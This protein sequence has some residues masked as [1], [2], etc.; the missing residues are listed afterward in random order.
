MKRD[1]LALAMVFAAILLFTHEAWLG[2]QSPYG[3]D[4]AEQFYPWKSF[5]RAQL[6]Q[7]EIPYWSPYTHAGAPFLANVQSAVFY[8]FDWVLFGFAMER[9]FGLSLVLHFLIA[10]AGAYC[11]ARVCG[12]T[13][14]PSMIAGVAYGLNGFAMIHIPFGNHLTYAGAA[15]A[16]W[17]LVTAT[18]FLFTRERRLLWWLAAAGVTFLHFTC[19]HPQMLFYSMVFSLAFVFML[20]AW[21]VRRDGAFTWTQPLWMTSLY[22][23]ALLL[24]V[25]MASFQLFATLEYAALANRAA[26]LDIDMAT[27]FS[28][29]P[30][31]LI[32]LLFPEYY[33]TQIGVHYDHYAY[34]SCAYAG[35]IV[36]FLALSMFRKGERPAAAV[37]LLALALLGLFLASG[38]GNPIY[39]LLLQL[40]GFGH[41]RAPAKFLPYYLVPIC[42]LAALGLERLAAEAYQKFTLKTLSKSAKEAE[43]AGL[44]P[45]DKTV[46]GMR[47]VGLAIVMCVVFLF[48][49]PYLFNL[50]D[51]LRNQLLNATGPIDMAG[52]TGATR[53]YSLV[54]GG[55]LLLSA[56]AIYLYAK[57]V[58]KAPRA[59][60]SFSLGLFLC[61]DLFVFGRGYFLA[62][63]YTANEIK[64]N[65]ATPP[66]VKFVQTLPDFSPVDRV[67]TMSNYRTPNHAVMWGLSN[68]AGY[69]PMSLRS[70]MKRIG[71]MEG[72]D[73]GA[74][75]DDINLEHFDHPVLDELNVRFILSTEVI[76]DPALKPLFTG[77][78]LRVYEQASNNHSW[79]WSAPRGQD[80]PD[81][82]DSMSDWSVVNADVT[83]YKPKHIAFDVEVSSPSWLRLAEWNY[84]NWRARAQ[85]GGGDWKPLDVVSTANGYRALS[86]D[87]G[88]WTVEMIYS[89]PWGRWLL[90][91]LAWLVFITSGVVAYLLHVG[92]FWK[93][94]QFMM[95]R[96]Y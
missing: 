37:P 4:I 54:I 89:E 51:A 44:A 64:A 22:G 68:T 42:A 21:R 49:S 14:F 45:S 41:F 30:H 33:G 47:I 87:A 7:G 52:L 1:A 26:T 81:N 71:E 59:V 62:T 94:A 88:Q 35:V 83:T 39:S 74:Y 46:A 3:G 96:Y 91:A 84:P 72:W 19:G 53:A 63:L 27:E 50:T 28:F 36:P 58:P 90:T 86:L 18:G 69:D 20:Q 43:F 11:F 31:R 55:V 16:P 92:K 24:G 95:G 23:F 9:F 56:M 73:D 8:V 60:L 77:P 29:A 82:L 70:F 17:M 32:T 2:G 80:G 67:Q 12:A 6:A 78:R 38:R 85:T 65:A 10:G 57:K 61:L 5:Q 76:E 15:W 75:H 25:L 34:W 93:F 66:A 13:Q 79:A 48:G 40:P